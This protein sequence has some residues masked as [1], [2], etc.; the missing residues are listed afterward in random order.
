[1]AYETLKT[2][3][4]NFLM[5]KLQIP[6]GIYYNLCNIL[7]N[8]AFIPILPM[9]ENRSYECLELRKEFTECSG[10]NPETIDVLNYELG[11]RGTGTMLELLVVLTFYIHYNLL[12]SEYDA[13][14]SKWFLEMLENCGILPY[15]INNWSGDE[16]VNNIKSILR[17]INLRR[18]NWDGEGSFFPIRFPHS[19][20]SDQRYEEILIQANN[21]IAENYD[22]C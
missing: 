17:I 3:Y 19:P 10:R 22:I 12:E 8:T 18:F 14:P 2:E 7:Q 21:Y 9:D 20:H 6:S 15:A 13:E 5:N 1:M 11:H 4:L 16:K